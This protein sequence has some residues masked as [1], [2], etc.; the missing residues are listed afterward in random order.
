MSL[1][2]SSLR[3]TR[4]SS[5]APTR[6]G[7]RSRSGYTA[8]GDQAMTLRTIRFDG[9]L[10]GV[11]TPSEDFV[12]Q[13]THKGRGTITTDSATI[14]MEHGRPQLWPQQGAAFSYD[15]LRPTHRADQPDRARDRRRERGI[16]AG[17]LQLDHTIRPDDR[18]LQVWRSSVQLISHNRHGPTRLAAAASRDGPAR[19]P[20]A[21]GALPGGVR[22]AAGR[23]A[24]AEEQP[25]PTRGRV[26][27]RTRTHLPITTD[28][29]AQVA[30]SASGRS[31]THSDD[32]SRSART[33]TSAECGSTGSVTPSSPA[34]WPR[35]TSATS[36]STGGSR[37]PAGS[38]PPTPNNTVSTRATPSA[39]PDRTTHDERPHPKR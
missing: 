24:A 23:A 12:V 16:A 14:E 33:H 37:T 36:A 39:A 19:R 22:S 11:M 21:A 6:P 35:P 9:H 32:S 3:R 18:A 7:S 31:S 10:D 25:H 20:R 1:A 26:H 30:T 28:D 5:G 4:D 29:V 17:N 2:T 34:T 27:P 38:P 15:D 13:W 8:V